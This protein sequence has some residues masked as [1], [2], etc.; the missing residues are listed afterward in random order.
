MSNIFEIRNYNV[1][2]KPG[3]KKGPSVEITG[4]DSLTVYIPERPHD[5]KA[6]AALIKLLSKYFNV[7]K[8]QIEIVRGE[9]SKQKNINIYFK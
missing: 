5:G 6:N 3:S 1:Y 9:K 2:V 8:S 7:S 4:E